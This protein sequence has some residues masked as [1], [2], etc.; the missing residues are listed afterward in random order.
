MKPDPTIRCAIYTRKSTEEG[1]DKEFN[2]LDAQRESAEA[3]IASQKSHGWKLVQTR[4]DDGGFSGGNT[5]RPALKRLM[6]DIEAGLIDCVVV[7]KVDRMS[8]SLLDFVQMLQSFERKQV[9]FVSVTQAFNTTTSMGRLTLNILLSFAQFER[10][11]ISERI[12]DKCAAS[13]RKGK[14]TGGRP[15]LGYDV[16]PEGRKLLVNE[17]EVAQVRRLFAAYLKLRSLSLLV[18]HARQQNWRNKTWINRKGDRIGGSFFTKSQLGDLLHNPIYI[19]QVVYKDERHAGEHPAIIDEKTF[20]AVQQVLLEQDRTGG[21]IHRIKHHALLRGLLRCGPCGCGMTHSYR[22]VRG[23]TRAYRHYVCQNR[24]TGNSAACPTPWL[25]AE[26]IERLV[27]D[28]I[29]DIG[30]DDALAMEVLTEM[31]S[32]GEAEAK[33]AA[34]RC[35]TAEAAVVSLDRSLRQ[36]VSGKKAIDPAQLADL[37]ERLRQAESEAAQARAQR[38]ALAAAVPEIGVARSAL[39]TFTPVL[40]ALCPQDQVQLMQ[41]LLTSVTVDAGSGNLVLAFRP[42]G[43]TALIEHAD[44]VETVS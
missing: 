10:E 37:N 25:P 22:S 39:R 40:R 35:S 36:A 7:Y 19:G 43:I 23:G 17:G 21:A 8:R 11:I 38:E 15:M 28:Q 29:A 16:A 26:E 44:P 24:N 4:Y 20:T 41:A 33:A 3:F 18:S 30:R 5:E 42:T 6:A 9:A 32:Q 2:T 12:R 34:E 14:W 13:R 1:L 27:V 31:R